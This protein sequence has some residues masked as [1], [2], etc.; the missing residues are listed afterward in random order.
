MTIRAFARPAAVA[1]FALALL[2]IAAPAHAGGPSLTLEVEKN[3]L[4][5]TKPVKLSGT[6]S[7]VLSG[8]DSKSIV[9]LR[10][11]YPYDS[12]GIVGT[13][14]TGA[15]GNF[16]FPPFQP[17]LNTRFRVTFQGD[18][19]D[20]SASSP[21]KQVFVFPRVEV[22][23][24]VT[25]RF[26]V[27]ERFDFFY[28]S[29]VQPEYYVGRKDLYLYFRK[30]SQNKYKRVDAAKFQDTFDG[31]GGTVKYKLPRSRKGYRYQVFPL[32]RGPSCRHRDRQ[33]QARNLPEAGEGA[34][35][36]A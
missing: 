24:S 4:R 2:V 36:G 25:P 29:M 30:T 18:V 21:V 32:R 10:S 27:K 31:V 12:E 35:Y 23:F 13:T 14:T 15:N 17:G 19:L 9:L 1:A 16:S 5:P 22:D 20:G 34:R 6:L 11:S 28:S 3:E 33:R 7:G 26:V 8:N